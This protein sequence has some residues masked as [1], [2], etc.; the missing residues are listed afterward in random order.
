M[1]TA[2]ALKAA[3]TLLWL[4]LVPFCL[5]LPFCAGREEKRFFAVLLAGYVL[6]FAWFQILAV[7]LIL[8]RQSYTLLVRLFGISSGAAALVCLAA[9]RKCVPAVLLSRK[10]RAVTWANVLAAALIAFQMGMYLY[11]MFRD[12]DDAM[13][14]GAASTAQ[15]TD[16]MYQIS[17]YTGRAAKALPAR[18]CLSPFPMFLAFVSTVSGF[19]VNVIAHNAEPVL[20]LA[21]AYGC[22]GLIGERLFSGDREKNGMF[23]TLI[24]LVCIFS[25]SSIYTQGTF[26]LTRIWQGKGVLVSVLLPAVLYGA[27]RFFDEEAGRREWLFLLLAVQACCMV[28]SMGILLGAV[29]LILL[30]AAFG[31]C[32]RRWRRAAAMLL[33][34]IP[35][36]C[37][38]ALYLW[39]R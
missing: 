28:S 31:V 18:Y 29:L 13:Y 19:S 6:Y 16:T 35:S 21:L 3:L 33:C 20:F 27:L 22:C 10:G 4:V 11:G 30:A 25:H 9:C 37:Y 39:I 34:C 26:M 15:Y 23:L 36:A 7:P 32:T 2:I 12:L 14:V 38:A 5:G 24:S 17:A 8:L 1:S